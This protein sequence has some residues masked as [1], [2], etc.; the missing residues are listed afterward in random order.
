MHSEDPD[1]ENQ[2]ESSSALVLVEACVDRVLSDLSADRPLRGCVRI[3]PLPG[4]RC[5]GV[6]LR[7]AMTVV[8][9]ELL[10]EPEANIRIGW[11]IHAEGHKLIFQGALP[12]MLMD[13]LGEGG[14]VVA[15]DKILRPSDGMAWM[16]R[17]LGAETA[18]VCFL[19]REPTARPNTPS[20]GC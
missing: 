18:S 17:S 15:A 7:K 10:K 19:L 1:H 12:G 11:Q 5:D 14:I 9:R 13:D 3:G 20:L 2:P 6:A 16:E 8:L 4:L